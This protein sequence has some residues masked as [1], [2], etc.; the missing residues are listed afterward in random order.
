M[1]F[2]LRRFCLEPLLLPSMLSLGCG[3]SSS[4]SEP[5]PLD[6]GAELKADANE[7]GE[8][9]VTLD[10]CKYNDWHPLSYTRAVIA[11]TVISSCAGRRRRVD[12]FPLFARYLY[13]P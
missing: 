5:A 2:V 7:L 6:A 10:S 11:S 8:T 3:V 12:P 4:S 1:D 9:A 13:A